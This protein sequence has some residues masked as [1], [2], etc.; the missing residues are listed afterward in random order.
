MLLSM[1]IAGC[2]DDIQGKD[3]KNDKENKGTEESKDKPLKIGFSMAT[4]QEE[5]WQKDRDE[6][7]KKAEELGAQVIV[8]DANNDADEQILQAENLISQGV[9]VLVVIAQ[10]GESAAKIVEAAHAEKIKVI[11]YDRLIK[12]SDLD[13]YVSF[14]NVSVGEI[15]AQNILDKYPTGDYILVGG[16]PSDNNAVL[17]R[18]GQMN[19]LKANIDKGDIKV[20]ADKWADGWNPEIA[21]KDVKDILASSDNK[22]LKAIVTSND[23]CAGGVVKALKEKGMDGKVGVSGQDADLAACQR[24]V[25]GTQ[26]V[27]VYKPINFLAGKVAELAVSFAKKESVQTDDKV[28]N[29]KIDVPSVLLDPLAVT[30]EN[31]NDVII[32]GGWQKVEDV[33]KNVP[34]DQWPK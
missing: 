7:V 18:D 31:M 6:F 23:G 10:D 15:Q 11:A 5:R 14:N 17:V 34:K 30:K 21:Y 9:D 29:G 20:I 22:N 1:C 3:V 19:V 32:K 27:T 12:N 28:N 8:K 13:L 33:Y 25:E 2:A 4:L 26:T 24:I 16:S